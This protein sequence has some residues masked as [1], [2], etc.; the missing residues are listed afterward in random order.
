MGFL[1]VLNL[2]IIQFYKV[3]LD[4]AYSPLLFSKNAIKLKPKTINSG[5]ID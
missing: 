2:E 1:S 4:R 5:S 3:K